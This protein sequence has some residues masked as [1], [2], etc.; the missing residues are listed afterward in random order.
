MRSQCYQ[1]SKSI[2]GGS[3]FPSA[4]S[5]A[6]RSPRQRLGSECAMEQ[7]GALICLNIQPCFLI[8]ARYFLVTNYYRYLIL[9]EY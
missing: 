2:K 7:I 1:S 5:A 4:E 9:K 3:S 8:F 6:Y